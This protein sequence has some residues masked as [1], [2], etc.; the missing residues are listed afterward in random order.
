MAGVW[1]PLWEKDEEFPP[2]APPPALLTDVGLSVA[3]P[4][5]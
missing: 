3:P 4:D 2:A 1:P 5:D